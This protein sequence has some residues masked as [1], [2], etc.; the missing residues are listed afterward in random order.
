MAFMWGDK[1]YH[2]AAAIVQNDITMIVQS[3]LAGGKLYI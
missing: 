2:R 1:R 3:L